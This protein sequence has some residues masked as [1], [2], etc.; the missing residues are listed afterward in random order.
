VDDPDAPG[1]SLSSNIDR[2]IHA[3]I[4]AVFS[5][6]LALD[7]AGNHSMAP[8]LSMTINKFSFDNDP[9]YGDN[10]LPAAPEYALRGEILYRRANGFYIGPGFDVIGERYADF[11][12]SYKVDSY[13]LLGLR[14]GWSGDR[15]RAFID[16]Q[17]LQDEDYIASHGV[18]DRA[19]SDA[20]ILNPGAP[21]SAYFGIQMQI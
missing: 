1:T 3:G 5:A 13:T 11:V 19:G 17:N 10:T 18:R 8:L 15:W 16:V 21:L 4:E 14:A 6:A 20:E 9:V 7:D 2:T 12:N